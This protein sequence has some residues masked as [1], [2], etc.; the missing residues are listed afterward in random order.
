[1]LDALLRWGYPLAVAG[2]LAVFVASQSL[3]G[4]TAT[5]LTAWSALVLGAGALLER[6]RP[7]EPRWRQPPDGPREALADWTSAA[8]LLGLT[9]PLLQAALPLLATALRTAWPAP[10]QWPLQAAPLAVQI[11]AALLWMELAKYG[12]HRL[13]HRAPALWPLHA[14][15]HAPRRLNWLNNLRMHPLN[16]AINSTAS[17]LPLL[18]IGVPS[19]VML[20]VLALT[21]PVLMLQHANVRS[22]NGWIN[23]VLSTNEAHRWHH[24]VDPRQADANYGSA[25]LLWDHVFGTYR[26]ATAD[27]RPDAV[28]LFASARFPS[29]GTYLQQLLAPL[30]PPCCRPSAS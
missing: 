20:G 24:A 10:L 29:R 21:Q 23:A 17:L 16:H 19:D 7:F 9:E 25:L 15:H 18:V 13:H 4:P 8:V 22:D 12:S 1:M 2:G 27:T 11:I 6:V 30:R 14:L 5:L 26:P 3:D 28:G